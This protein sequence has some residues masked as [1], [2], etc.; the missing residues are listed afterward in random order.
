ME[1]KVHIETSEE[2]VG[3]MEQTRSF[4]HIYSV[5]QFFPYLQLLKAKYYTTI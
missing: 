2:L 1:Q 5:S 3:I 4:P